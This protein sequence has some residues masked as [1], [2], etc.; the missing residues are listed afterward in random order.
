MAGY[1]VPQGRKVGVE[2]RVM[3]VQE[4]SIIDGLCVE[5]RVLYLGANIRYEHYWHKD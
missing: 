3:R 2:E 1:D 5:C 4:C